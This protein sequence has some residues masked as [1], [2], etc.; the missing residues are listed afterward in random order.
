M[1]VEKDSQKGIV[2]GRGGKML[3]DIVAAA[4]QEIEGMLGTQVFLELWVKVRP[5]WRRDEAVLRSIGYH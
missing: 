3:K 4:R 5:K 1:Y 2:I